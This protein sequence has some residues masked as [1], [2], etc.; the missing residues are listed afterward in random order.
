M[1]Y[2]SL[3]P[4]GGGSGGVTTIN[5]EAGAI[6]L[7][8]SGASITITTPTASTI[9]LESVSGG[10]GTVTSV[11]GTNANGVAFSIANPTSTPNITLTL[12]AITPSTVNA[13]TLASQAVGFTIAGGTISKTL[14]VPLT[15]SVAGTNTGDITLSGENYV[16]LSGQA[17]TAHAVDLS[18]T[19]VTGNLPVTN[20]NS[21][22]SASSSTFWRGDGTWATPGGGGSGT[23]TS[24]TFT[25]DGVVLSST[26]SGAVTTSGTVTAA[27]ANAGAGTVLGNATSSSAAPTYTSTPQLGKSGTLGS[28]TFGNATSGLLTLETA[29]GALGTVTVSIPAATDTLVNLA[30]TQTLSNKTFVAPALGTPAS[31]VVTNLT[32]TAGINITGTAPAGT[33]TGT[34]LNSTVVTSSLTTVGILGTGTWQANKIGLAYGGTNADLSATG[35]TSNVLKQTSSGAAITVA[36]LAASDLSNGTTGSGGG[37][38]L[39]TSPTLSNPVVGTQSSSDNSTKAASTA[40]VTTAVT[41]ALNGLD[42]KPAVKYATTSNQVGTNTAGVFT[43]TSTGVNTPDGTALA[44][45]DNVLYKNQTTGADNGVWVVTT[46]GALGIAGVLTRR[47]DYNT[48]ADIHDG[49]TFFVQ[50]G[51]VNAATSWVQ[52]DVVTTINTDPLAFSQVAGPGTYTNGTGLSLTGNVFSITNTAVSAASYG[53]STSIPSFTV[54]A[55]GQLT[56]ASGNAV[57]APAGTLTGT[58][59]ASNVVT[60]S[61]TAV[62]ALA[63]GSLTTGF[64]AVGIAQGGTGQTTRTAAFD[65]LAPASPAQGDILYYNGSH[66]VDLGAG[67]SGQFLQTQGASANPQ[68]AAAGGGGATTTS[69]S[70]TAH[71]FSVGQ[72]VKLTGATTYALAKADSSADAEV[73]GIVSAVAG[74]NAFTLT[75]GGYV[76]GLSGLTAATTYFLDPSTAGALTATIPTTQGQVVKPVFIADSTTSGIFINMRGEIL[77]TSATNNIYPRDITFALPGAR[78]VAN[79]LTNWIIMTHA[80]QINKAWAI[81]KTGPTGAAL[82]FDI[83]KSTNNGSSFTSIWASTPANRV[84]IAAAAVSG[85]QTSFDTTTFNAGDIF[86]IDI[87][88]VGSTIAGSD[89]TVTLATLTQNS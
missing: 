34:T 84:Q 38:V 24:V 44:L 77:G 9:N 8:S 59:L 5:G 22:T 66:W 11:A 78:I 15:A 40:Y 49:D 68:W 3:I 89:I 35:G 33:L 67:T 50:N 4:Q 1:V 39:A 37:V 28:I 85:N 6:T 71:G 75:T 45:N 36:Q 60:S 55:Q 86:R 51:T 58:T 52:T 10:A 18:G 48:A 47:S 43:Y 13:L 80:G 20:L 57:I 27:L 73:A 63:S 17:I 25:G 88:Q 12:G 72:L 70:Q 62:G 83:Q 81:A 64:T 19:N 56:A 53:S 14:T 29:T 69:V 54:N 31:G 61:L 2:N 26:P 46:A 82:I 7:T 30:G 76:T 16:T 42:W 87:D 23:V 41:N 21:G 65:A 74:A 79:D 32:G